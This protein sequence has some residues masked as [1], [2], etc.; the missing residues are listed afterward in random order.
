MT[1][2]LGAGDI[3]GDEELAQRLACKAKE[4]NVDVVVLC[5]DIS[6]PQETT[7]G[8][9]GPFKQ[10]N[11]KVLLVP[12]NHESPAT[13]D[14]LSE[15][16]DVKSLHGYSARYDDIGIFGHGAV[17]IGMHADSENTIF[18]GLLQA[19]EYISYLTKK[20][21]V[22][23]VHPNDSLMGSMSR[24]IPGSDAVRK[25]ISQFQPDI[26]LCSHVHEAH[27]LEETI[28][29]TKVI[30]VGREGKIIDL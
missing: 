12:G 6:G 29:K 18:S 11:L 15:L 16:Y 21:M 28:E 4:N 9:L 17:N 2:I 24:F 8:L 10:A 7:Q 27:G 5:G 19:H 25:A 26:L 20:V 3:H 30:N 1:R 13:T 14:F 22:T 23:H